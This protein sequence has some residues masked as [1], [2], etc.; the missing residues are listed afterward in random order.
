MMLYPKQQFE[1]CYH[2][3]S[4]HLWYFDWPQEGIV[5]LIRSIYQK[6]AVSVLLQTVDKQVQ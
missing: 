2:I 5:H 1:C 4:L 6:S 3:G